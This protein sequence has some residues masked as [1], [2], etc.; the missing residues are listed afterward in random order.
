MKT[1]WSFIGA[2]LMAT[3]PAM[4]QETPDNAANINMIHTALA[5]SLP[6]RIYVEIGETNRFYKISYVTRK[7]ACIIEYNIFAADTLQ[8][9]IKTLD[10][11]TID[12]P[13]FGDDFV[14]IN[15]GEG[16]GDIRRF[17]VANEQEAKNLLSAFLYM[18]NIC[19]R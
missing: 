17:Y 1:Y 8:K 10:F 4:T 5:N 12:S 3:S 19:K 2:A 9:T 13:M 16:F 15:I 6:G 14:T 7:T 18:N 11:G